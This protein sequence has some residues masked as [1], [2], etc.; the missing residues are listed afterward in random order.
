MIGIETDRI[1]DSLTVGPGRAGQG[2]GSSRTT[3]P[4][5]LRLVYRRS[6]LR[7]DLDD[8]SPAQRDEG[9]ETSWPLGLVFGFLGLGAVDV[10]SVAGSA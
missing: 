7:R 4:W 5:P 3:L 8:V 2:D 10:H 6:S 1:F 9:R